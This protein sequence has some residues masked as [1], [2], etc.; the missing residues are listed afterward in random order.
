MFHRS[1][2]LS[3]TALGVGL[4]LSAAGMP[5]AWGAPASNVDI[6]TVHATTTGTSTQKVKSAP[7]QAPSKTPLP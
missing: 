7:Y 1:K 3:R 4:C 2:L 6:G 5:L